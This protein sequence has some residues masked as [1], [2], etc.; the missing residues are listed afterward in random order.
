MSAI[1]DSGIILPPTTSAAHAEH[2]VD[3]A[4]GILLIVN[5]SKFSGFESV[6]RLLVRAALQG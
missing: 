2:V 4:S 5:A 3:Q 1:T 6:S